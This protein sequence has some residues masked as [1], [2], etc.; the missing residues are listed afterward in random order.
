MAAGFN[1]LVA[2]REFDDVWALLIN[3]ITNLVLLRYFPL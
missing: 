2:A 3:F 1:L